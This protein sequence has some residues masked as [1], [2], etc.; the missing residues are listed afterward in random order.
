M[1]QTLTHVFFLGKR[2]RYFVLANGYLDRRG[3][4]AMN[5]IKIRRYQFL[6]LV[7]VFQAKVLI[8]IF[9]KTKLWQIYEYV[10]NLISIVI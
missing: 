4:P 10:L 8:N 2:G 9:L 3:K 5:T 7:W 6:G 1:L